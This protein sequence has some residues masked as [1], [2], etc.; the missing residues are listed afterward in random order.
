MTWIT[1]IVS[2]D[3]TQKKCAH[4]PNIFF[5]EY[6]FLIPERVG[7]MSRGTTENSYVK[8]CSS[9]WLFKTILAHSLPAI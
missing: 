7:K 9:V 5:G 3:K 8:F 6:T 1:D 4:I 2:L